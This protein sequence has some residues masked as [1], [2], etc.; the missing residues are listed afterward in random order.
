MSQAAEDATRL[1]IQVT[2]RCQADKQDAL[3]RRVNKERGLG[4]AV[5]LLCADCP[6]PEPEQE[7]EEEG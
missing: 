3:L 2:W 6:E 1:F 4:A 7:E 5:R